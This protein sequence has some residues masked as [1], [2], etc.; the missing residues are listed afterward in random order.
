MEQARHHPLRSRSAVLVFCAAIIGRALD[1]ANRSAGLG[2]LG[3]EGPL[4]AVHSPRGLVPLGPDLLPE[5]EGEE[6]RDRG[7]GGAAL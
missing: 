7:L 4:L 2:D 5:P 3:A 6:L 1:N